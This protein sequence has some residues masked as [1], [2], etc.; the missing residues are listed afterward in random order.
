ME[1]KILEAYYFNEELRKQNGKPIDM[2][3]SCSWTR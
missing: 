1:D 3:V 2:A